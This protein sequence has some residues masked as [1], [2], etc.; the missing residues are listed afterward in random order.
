[1]NAQQGAEMIFIVIKIRDKAR[2]D[3]S[4]A[5]TGCAVHRGHPRRAARQ[6]YYTA[7]PDLPDPAATV[8]RR[9]ARPTQQFQRTPPPPPP[10]SFAEK[11]RLSR[12]LNRQSIVLVVRN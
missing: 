2:V 10:P 6:G 11:Q 5:R 7:R 4:L 3:R 8:T 12:G 1:M 9:R